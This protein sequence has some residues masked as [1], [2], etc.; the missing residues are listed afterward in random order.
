MLVPLFQVLEPGDF[1]FRHRHHQLSADVVRNAVLLAERHHLA[2]A[3]YGK[4]GFQRTGLVVEPAVK[5]IGVVPALVRGNRG[6]LLIHG[7]VAPRP[8]LKQTQRYSKPDYSSAD[9]RDGAGQ[10]PRVHK[11]RG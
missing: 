3:R 2:D 4:L 1:V 5:N 7:N 8:A 10:V 9:N 11:E 6:L